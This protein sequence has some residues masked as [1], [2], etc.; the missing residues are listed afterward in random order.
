MNITLPDGS[1][2]DLP[3]GASGYDLAQ[4]ISSGLARV[5]L[6]VKVDGEVRDLHRELPDGATV[7]I[8]TWDDPE[9]KAAFWHSTA[10][11]MA[12]A[13]EALYSG[14]QFGTG[15]AIENGF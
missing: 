4:S 1:V 2:R 15:P 11:L 3:D 6:A 13:L 9:G 5:A 8:L 14:V 10:H 12:E 7:H